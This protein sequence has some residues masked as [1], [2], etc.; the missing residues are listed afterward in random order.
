[1]LSPSKSGA[2]ITFFPSTVKM[3]KTAEI[4]LG[5]P[6]FTVT[7]FDK[8]GVIMNCQSK[9]ITFTFIVLETP[10]LLTFP[11]IANNLT[12]LLVSPQP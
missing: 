12:L 6:A 8:L 10:N 7:Y 1:M 4:I 11:I 2:G 3:L 5:S 9:I